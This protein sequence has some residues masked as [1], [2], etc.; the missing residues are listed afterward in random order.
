MAPPAVSQHAGAFAQS[1]RSSKTPSECTGKSHS[2]CL[3]EIDNQIIPKI[4]GLGKGDISDHDMLRTTT[5]V[6][7]PSP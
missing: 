1:S 3:M 7:G 5:T 6:G 2:T 4:G